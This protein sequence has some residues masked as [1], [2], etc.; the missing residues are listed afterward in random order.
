MSSIF[1]Q[2]PQ[3]S[4]TSPRGFQAGA[5]HSGIK[6]DPTKP[7]LMVLCSEQPCTVAATFT[8]NLFAAAPVVLDRERVATGKARAIVANS[9][10]ANAC[11]GAIGLDN[12]RQMASWAGEK[13]NVPAD[14]V[15]VAS[16][17]VIGVHLPMRAIQGGLAKL[18]IGP[19]G[20]LEAARGIMTTDTQPKHIAVEFEVDGQKVRVGG[21]AKGAAM[22]HPN[23]AT[24]LCFV[25]TDAQAEPA[26]LQRAL[27]K[28]VDYS[29][30]MISVDGDTSTNDTCIV[31]ANGLSGVSVDTG[32]A[33]VQ[34]QGALDVVAQHLAKAIVD[35]AEGSQ[36]TMR[37]EVEGAPSAEIAR[38]VGRTIASSTLFKAALHGA[39]PNWGR[40]LCA[41]G[42]SEVAIDPSR[43][44]LSV[45]GIPLV[46]EGA[47]L[48][49][50]R[51]AATEAMKADEV[52][53]RLHLHQGESRA[54]AWGCELTEQYVYE[55]SAYTT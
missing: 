48:E 22:I 8:R 3:G 9:G 20:G 51:E 4:V 18:S 52:L 6:S 38:T 7:D 46:R 30:N 13:L 44:E 25:T 55:N 32:Q 29:F 21:I 34:F 36:R 28:A 12:A 35:D 14:E 10:N 43:V 33:F 41:V 42:Y 39:D 5:I 24:M 11:T 17:G 49:F 27:G 2:L 26:T 54:V 40:I 50:D 19:E 1:N 16:T 23:M 15:L 45:A 47:P 53:V 31:L 37:I